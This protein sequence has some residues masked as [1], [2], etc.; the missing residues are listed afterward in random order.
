MPGIT[1]YYGF[2]EYWELR[3]KVTFDGVNRLIIVN[4]NETSLD[5]Q[6]DIYS[7]WKEWART[8][9]NLKYFEPLSTVGGE[10]T[11]EGQRLDVTY[12]LIN[13]WKIKP[14]SG[15]YD[16]NIVG[17]I[18]DVDGGSIKVPADVNP[19]VPNNITIN[20]NTSV[21]VRQVNTSGSGGG[22]GIVTASLV[23][24]QREALFDISGSVV[25]I[26]SLL[27]TQP[28]TASLVDSQ[29]SILNNIQTKLEE[30]W[31]LHGLDSGSSL[32]VSQTARSFDDIV[33]SIVT[34]GSG[35]TQETTITRLP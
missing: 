19:N 20:T 14:Y 15:T 5:V 2:W 28:I 10:P 33:Q 16:L 9:N 29:L 6:T 11:I 3:H 12:F 32:F 34:I 7:D 24:D 4:D 13:G 35:S 25:A 1:M 31:K 23:D 30:V 26:Y 22:G 21:I 8:E 27:Q 17:N 18:F